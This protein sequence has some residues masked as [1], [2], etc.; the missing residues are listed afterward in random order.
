[1][2]GA[3]YHDAIKSWLGSSGS[4]SCCMLDPAQGSNLL[5][6]WEDAQ[7]KIEWQDGHIRALELRLADLHDRLAAV[8]TPR[9]PAWTVIA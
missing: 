2:S 9:P 4:R 1:M 8:S 3:Y 6:E 7:A 5:A